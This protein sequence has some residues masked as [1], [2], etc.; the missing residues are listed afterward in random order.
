M[1]VFFRLFPGYLSQLV[2]FAILC[3]FPFQKNWRYSR[4]KTALITVSIIMGTDALFAGSGAVLAFVLPAND[5]LFYMV[6]VV[7]LI[8]LL[9]CFFWYLYAI[10]AI[11]QK[12]LF[13]FSFALISALLAA[14][15][16]NCII[17]LPETFYDYADSTYLPYTPGVVAPSAVVYMIVALSLCL[18]L[19]CFYLPVEE[20]LGKKETGYLAFLSLF[21]FAILTFIFSQVNF[22]YLISDRTMLYLF[23]TL[24]L[25]V[26]LLYGVMF[27][28]YALAHEQHIAH[29]KYL[30]SQYRNNIRDEQYRR[31]LDSIEHN[32]KQRHDLRHHLLTLQT[33]WENGETEK[34]RDYLSRYLGNADGIHVEKFCSHP[35][36]NMLVSHYF[37]LAGERGVTLTAHIHVP[38]SF[39]IQDT[40]LSILIGNLL[41]NA[42]EAAE[43]A[44]EAYR[45][46]HLNMLCRGQMFAVTV[47]NGFDGVIQEEGGRYLSVKSGHHGLGLS[48]LHEMAEKYGGGTEFTHDAMIFHSSVMLNGML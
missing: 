38:D 45:F 7:F 37:S 4:K 24:F 8:C 48:I 42:L 30:R 12:K 5:T 47:D 46:I 17:N 36:I 15:V 1:Q 28:M 41:E 29:E 19:H 18:F 33:L 13:I 34:A 25:I 43:R 9:P 20:G 39:S 23:F 31:I 10:K 3:A 40:D 14:S 21:L 35:I 6:T 2:P 22:V 16:W 27:K 26:F 44:P 11:W 32:R